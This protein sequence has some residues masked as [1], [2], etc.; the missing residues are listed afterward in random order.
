MS[1]GQKKAGSG[2]W[3]PYHG[4]AYA[5]YQQPIKSEASS[6]GA[7]IRTDSSSSNGDAMNALVGIISNG[8][9]TSLSELQTSIGE[10]KTQNE[11]NNRE[12]KEKLDGIN[13]PSWHESLFNP[14]TLA[15]L[16][17][18]ILLILSFIVGSL[19][20]YTGIKFI[21][22]KDLML[23]LGG[24]LVGLLGGEKINKTNK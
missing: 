6:T 11:N 12:I 5:G 1:N 15:V 24:G 22:V 21:D 23:L 2:F 10:V 9:T 16:G 13:K 19:Q 20:K 3:S 8:I 7:P 17:V 4:G 18:V 14:A